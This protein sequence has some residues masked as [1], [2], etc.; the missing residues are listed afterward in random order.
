MRQC[1]PWYS[2]DRG[3]RLLARNTLLNLAGQGAPGLIAIAA[4]PVLIDRLGTERFG[5]L[6]LMWV[7]LNYISVLDFGIGRAI[8]KYIADLL[9]TERLSEIP[10]VIGTG[11]ILMLNL[12]IAAAV[13][14]GAAA[15]WIVTGALNLGGELA[16]EAVP[17]LRLLAVAIPFVVSTAGMRGVLEALQR[18]DLLNFVRFP[19]SAF[20]FLGP[21]LVLPFSQSLVPIVSV[22]V[23]AR[24]LACLFHLIFCYRNVPELAAGIGVQS[25]I[26]SALVRYGGW[27]SV[28]N[29]IGPMLLYLDRFLLAG[30]ISV[31]AV[32][33]Y[34][35]PYEAVT[36]LWFIPRGIIE[37]LFPAFG[38]ALTRD[39][40]AARRLYRQG[41]MGTILLLL[42]LCLAILFFAGPAL[43]L[44]LGRDFAEKS[45]GIA[46]LL[47]IGV[48]LNSAGL[49]S[50]ALIQAAGR[51]DLT[52][53]LHL[54]EFPTYLIYLYLLIGRFGLDGA[55]TAWVLRVG[56]SA[57]VL[58]CV[59]RYCL[60][61][62]ST[63]ASDSMP[64]HPQRPPLYLGAAHSGR[65]ADS[66]PK[67]RV[68]GAGP[69]P[70]FGNE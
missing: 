29:V 5:A 32:A 14:V 16:E 40:A 36:H 33:Y 62:Q 10:A 6:A 30:M 20:T 57:V 12:G 1:P 21:L 44:W 50:T 42:P 41:M 65:T 64:E 58:A 60:R 9:G 22:L 66:E 38:V 69:H 28:S 19:L 15:P 37:V 18:F 34:T 47:A 24:I 26:A 54:L 46:R 56:I 3:N 43:E 7:I 45:A 4:I 51:P 67:Y 68:G 61:V 49:V 39:V 8:T 31:T 52:A 11:L 70:S 59:A 13:V 55:A 17:A 53:K 27:L 2:G 63:M 23:L 35:T 25:S 48:L